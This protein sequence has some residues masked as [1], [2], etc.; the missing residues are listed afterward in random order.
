ML[1]DSN[2][3]PR[4]PEQGLEEAEVDRRHLRGKNFISRIAHFLG[5]DGSRFDVSGLDL[6]GFLARGNRCGVLVDRG[7][8]R[9][10]GHGSSLRNRRFQGTQADLRGTQ[11]RYLVNL[12]DCVHIAA[13]LKD[14]LKLVGG[15]CVNTTTEGVEL[16][17]LKV[18]LIAHASGGL[19]QA[20]MVG[21]LVTH[22]KR[23]LQALVDDGVLGENSHSQSDNDLGNTVVD[24]GVEVVGTARQDDS[25]HSMFTHPRERFAALFLDFILNCGVFFPRLIQR[26]SHFL[27]ADVVAILCEG[28]HQ[29]S[30]Q[31][32]TVAE[33]DEGADELHARLIQ[34]FHVVAD[35]FGVGCNDRAVEVVIRVGELLLEVDAGVPDRCDSLVQQGFDVSVDEFGRVAH[36][37][38]RDRFHSLLEELVVASA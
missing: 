34:A 30:G 7:V 29:V 13:S 18:R 22:A 4:T 17:H 9:S 11:V 3:E 14:L 5:E 8:D 19:V 23:A 35:D 1:K 6:L 15:D 32:V 31:V 27:N 24:F 16:D 33:V 12:E 28:A 25:T 21:P 37:F 36:V 26:A 20:R 2:I 38:R 10:R